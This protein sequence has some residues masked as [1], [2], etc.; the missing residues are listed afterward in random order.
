MEVKNERMKP[1]LYIE[2]ENTQ[3]TAA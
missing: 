3:K 2:D 1:R